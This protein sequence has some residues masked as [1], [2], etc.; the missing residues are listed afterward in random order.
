MTPPEAAGHRRHTIE[1][2]RRHVRVEKTT[3][4][5]NALIQVHGVKHAIDCSFGWHATI[6]PSNAGSLA[7]DRNHSRTIDSIWLQRSTIQVLSVRLAAT[8][9]KAAPMRRKLVRW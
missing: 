2:F 8:T 5:A 6:D 3:S 4:V 1:A 9:H 7:K